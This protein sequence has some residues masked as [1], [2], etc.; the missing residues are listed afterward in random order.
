MS[1]GIVDKLVDIRTNSINTSL[2]CRYAIALA[3]HAYT[4]PHYCTKTQACH[5]CRSATMHTCKIAAEKE[6]EQPVEDEVSNEPEETVQPDTQITSQEEEKMSEEEPKVAEDQTTTEQTDYR[7]KDSDITS[8]EVEYKDA[9]GQW[10]KVEND[11]VTPNDTEIYLKVNFDKIQTEALLKQHNCTLAYQ[12]PD[13]LRDA[14]GAGD[15]Y[16]GNNKIGTITVENGQ[17]KVNLDKTYLEGLISKR[18]TQ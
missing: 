1:L 12:I 10:Q 17:A 6:E 11:E 4:L 15:L 16:E 7:L 9:K 5:T 14:Q 18:L 8:I 13:F 3:L 2:H